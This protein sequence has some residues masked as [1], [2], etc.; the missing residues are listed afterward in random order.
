MA[1][2]SL[3]AFLRR[4]YSETL[5][6]S[7]DPMQIPIRFDFFGEDGRRITAARSYNVPGNKWFLTCDG[8]F[9]SEDLTWERPNT[10]IILR[11]YSPSELLYNYPGSAKALG[12]PE[13]DVQHVTGNALPDS[14]DL[15]VLSDIDR[16]DWSWIRE[17]RWPEFRPPTEP[18]A[19]RE[20]GYSTFIYPD[21][22]I[23]SK[24]YV[25]SE[26]EHAMPKV[27]RFETPSKRFDTFVY[28]LV[29]S[30]NFDL[31]PRFYIRKTMRDLP[32]VKS[33]WRTN[34]DW[35]LTE[36]IKYYLIDEVLEEWEGIREALMLQGAKFTTLLEMQKAQILQEV[37][38]GELVLLETEDKNSRLHISFKDRRIY[39]WSDLATPP[40]SIGKI[41]FITTRGYSGWAVREDSTTDQWTVCYR[42]DSGETF[43]WSVDENS[44]SSWATNEDLSEEDPQYTAILYEFE[45]FETAWPSIWKQYEKMKDDLWYKLTY[46]GNSEE[47]SPEEVQADAIRADNDLKLPKAWAFIHLGLLFWVTESRS[48]RGWYVSRRDDDYDHV[49]RIYTTRGTWS[50]GG[51]EPRYYSP[52]ELTEE[53]PMALE[54]LK[55]PILDTDEQQA[56][57]ERLYEQSQNKL[58]EMSVPTFEYLYSKMPYF[59]KGIERFSVRMNDES[60]KV[61]KSYIYDFNRGDMVGRLSNE[62]IQLGQLV[63]GEQK[64]QFIVSRHSPMTRKEWLQTNGGWNSLNAQVLWVSLETI[65]GFF[66]DVNKFNTEN[67]LEGEDDANS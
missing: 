47:S 3:A 67:L 53:W 32:H 1:T 45:D 37:K 43:W 42:D 29:K 24:D 50:L 38:D 11:Y 60:G 19:A 14:H 62:G 15:L 9:Y 10:R 54:A 36:N 35:T 23:V 7:E 61:S 56:E 44:V 33:F 66:K 57:V 4:P 17:R 31:P 49:H 55:K 6:T 30:D 65:H 46:E 20:E 52:F 27:L 28:D 41:D 21:D 5:G 48:G 8:D 2:K 25:V 59:F 39:S 26:L 63:T 58:E 34:E 22:H 51:E 12:F 18:I 16:S 40:D 13:S 64:S